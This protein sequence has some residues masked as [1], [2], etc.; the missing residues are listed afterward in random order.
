MTSPSKYPHH[1]SEIVL[2]DAINVL[3]EYF[4]NTVDLVVTSPPYYN[5]REE[6]ASYSNVQEYLDTMGY[7]FHHCSRLLRPGRMFCVNI[8]QDISFDL[9]SKMSYV[10]EGCGLQYFDTICWDKGGE[11]GNRGMHIQNGKYYPNYRWEPIFIYRK[12]SGLDDFPEFDFADMEYINSVL[13]TN[14]WSVSPQKGS[15]HPAPYPELLVS[16]LIRCYSKPGQIVLDPF[17][18]SGTT[19]KAA[20]KY[21]RRYLLIERNS[22]YH[23][24]ALD[25]INSTPITLGL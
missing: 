2:G 1:E 7:I 5:Q 8:G 16:N 4:E 17:G 25:E 13:R 24:R 22:E 19:A 10:L 21:H 18:G 3:P 14:V 6:Y 9:P 20:L 11:I 15:W 23:K 12:P